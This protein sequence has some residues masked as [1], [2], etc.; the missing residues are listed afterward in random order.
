MKSFLKG[1]V[2]SGAVAVSAGIGQA[3]PVGTIDVLWYGQ[4]AS[5]NTSMTGLAAG[6]GTYDPLNDGSLNW[7]LTIW[8][9]GDP[10][11]TFS[12]YDVFVIGS[13]Q[14]FGMGFDPTRLLAAKAAIE[15]ARGTRTFLSGQDADYHYQFGP[16]PI[17]NGPRGFLI[18]AVNWAGSGTGMGIVSLPDGYVGSG[19]EWW[20]NANSFLRNEILGTT[21]YF[22]EENVV[23]PP[24]SATFPVNEGL[25][26]AGLSNW[27]VSSHSGFSTLP[28]GYTSINDSGSIPGS[29]VTIVTASAAG[30]CTTGCGDPVAVPEPMSL[31]L[32]GSGLAGLALVRRRRRDL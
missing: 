2:L 17:D 25:T 3:A 29:F 4:S 27:S 11:P 14:V 30:G 16:G 5:Y 31:F 1:L 32:F 13:S 26:T 28:T 10:T 24:G 6:A 9:A 18:N 8:N 19:S 12:N 15:A 23:I 22:Q 20:D 7:N 21:A